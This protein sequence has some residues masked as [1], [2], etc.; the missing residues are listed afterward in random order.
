MTLNIKSSQ[1]RT[2]RHFQHTIVIHVYGAICVKPD[3]IEGI[4]DI[5]LPAFCNTVIALPWCT[6]HPHT[7]NYTITIYF[8][9]N[10]TMQW[11]AVN[12]LISKR[13][14]F[15]LCVTFN[16][17]FFKVDFVIIW[18]LLCFKRK[19]ILLVIDLYLI[20]NTRSSLS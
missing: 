8:Q 9:C 3:R 5:L 2:V 18:F 10:R 20:F 17:L 1:Q 11:T 4:P 12:L 16:D 13:G 14:S 7:I 19:F 15:F 6:V